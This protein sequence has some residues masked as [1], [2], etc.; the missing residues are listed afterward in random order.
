MIIY[1]YCVLFLPPAEIIAKGVSLVKVVCF[2][3]ILLM[4]IEVDMSQKQ[5]IV[6]DKKQNNK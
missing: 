6:L 5:Q 4:L 3:I 1:D 2:L